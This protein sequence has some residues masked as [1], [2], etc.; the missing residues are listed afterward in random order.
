MGIDNDERI[1]RGCHIIKRL[2]Q[3]EDIDFQSRD[4]TSLSRNSVF[5]V[6]M[7]IDLHR[8]K[9]DYQR[10]AA[11]VFRCP[12]AGFRQRDDPYDTPGIPD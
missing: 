5:D 11:E 9:F 4:I 10:N 8:Q 1:I 7:M 3:L 6:G 2:S 12:G